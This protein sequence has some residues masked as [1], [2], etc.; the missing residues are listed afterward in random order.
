MTKVVYH[1]ILSYGF[2]WNY[3]NLRSMLIEILIL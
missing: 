3:N 2:G 1:G